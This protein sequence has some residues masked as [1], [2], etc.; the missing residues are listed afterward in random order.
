MK[1]NKINIVFSVIL[2][3]LLIYFLY[4]IRTIYP[5][6]IDNSIFVCKS[7]LNSIPLFVQKNNRCS[8]LVAFGNLLLNYIKNTLFRHSLH[9][10]K[11]K[12][13]IIISLEKK[14]FLLNKII[15]FRNQK[16]MA[17][18]MGVLKPKI[19]IS[20]EVLKRMTYPEIEAIILHERQHII[21]KDNLVMLF[22]NY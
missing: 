15:I 21:G 17:F 14:Y 1:K 3:G 12:P 13:K 10:V 19:F 18:C 11:L 9:F 5:L 2:S 22:L 7:C 16:L 20:S 8:M 6:V 4:L